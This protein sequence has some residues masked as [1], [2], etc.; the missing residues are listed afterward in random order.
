VTAI[1]V[2]VVGW[3]F[4]IFFALAW[5]TARRRIPPC[6]LTN[7]TPHT[8]RIQVAPGRWVEVPPGTCLRIS[9]DDGSAPR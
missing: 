9:A 2:A 7:H 3:G 6:E 1:I 4:A 5:S 8:A